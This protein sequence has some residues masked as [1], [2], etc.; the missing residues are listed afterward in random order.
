MSKKR[1]KGFTLIELLVVVAIIALLIAILLPSLGKAKERAKLTACGANL[2]SLAQG[3]LT[4]ASEWSTEL[5]VMNG[6]SV[7]LNSDGTVSQPNYS[8]VDT[9]QYNNGGIWGLGILAQTGTVN[10]PRVYYCPSQLNDA[11][12]YK[13]DLSRTTIGGWL[14]LSDDDS[15]TGYMF[16]IHGIPVSGSG[17]PYKVKNPRTGD[18][19]PQ[20]IM[21]CDIIWGKSYIA[22]GSS[23][24]PGNTL[25]N[26]M[27]IDGHVQAVNGSTIR[28]IGKNPDGSL[29]NPATA[30]ISAQ[31]GVASDINWVFTDDPKNP[32]FA[33][34]VGSFTYAAWD[35]EYSAQKK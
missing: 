1:R 10:D 16:Q 12:I 7:K 21:G 29:H 33:P 9:Y 6:G 34:A 24:S 3:A 26:C 4:Y 13:G 18:Y 19:S 22:H 23:N 35:L 20:E 28:P 32:S 27:F 30:F 25:F 5:P 2:H 17:K 14:K 15:R 31:S 8:S 11:F